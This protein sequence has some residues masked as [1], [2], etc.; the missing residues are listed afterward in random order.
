M[1]GAR[2]RELC[3]RRG[4]RR[5]RLSG[6]VRSERMMRKYLLLLFVAASIAGCAPSLS[7]AE[8][9]A[10][11][12][13]ESEI[14]HTYTIRSYDEARLLRMHARKISARALRS[15][16]YRVLRRRMLATVNNPA[17]EGVGIAAPQVGVGRRVIAVQRYDKAGEPFEFFINPEILQYG[18]SSA[19]GMEGC[20]SVP[21]VYGKVLRPQSVRLRY[22]D[23][24]YRLRTETVSGFTAVILQHEVDHLNGILFIDRMIP[25]SERYETE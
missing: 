15:D 21:V 8:R 2:Q 12:A 10:I 11:H 18:D 19:V 5:L 7:D 9:A 16:D 3:G 25:G 14:M 22:R 4:M 20:L 6:F 1:H 17:E 13:G 23:E 24:D